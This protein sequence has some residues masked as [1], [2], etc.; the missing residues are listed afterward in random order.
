MKNKINLE[1]TLG[2]ISVITGAIYLIGVYGPT[3]AEIANW[4]F[5]A[6]ILGG[7]MIFFGINKGEI[8][9][10]FKIILLGFLLLIQ[11]PA[12][13]LWFMFHGSNISDGTP[14]TQ[15]IAHWIFATPHIMIVLIG[16]AIIV[17]T[18]K[19]KTA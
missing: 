18:L 16:V 10:L 15:F 1:I 13:F 11:L 6:T 14:P 7:C 12:I 4:G 2:I 8:T 3:E 19:Q 9:N 5:I 17:T